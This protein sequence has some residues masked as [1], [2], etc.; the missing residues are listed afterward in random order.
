MKTN[1]QNKIGGLSGAWYD[2]ADQ[3]WA[4]FVGWGWCSYYTPQSTEVPY[5]D[6]GGPK[7]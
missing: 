4:H 1:W 6:D 5:L 2:K 7:N 3:N